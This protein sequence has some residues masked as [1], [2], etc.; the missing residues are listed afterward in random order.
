M[1]SI[2]VYLIES[3]RKG[4]GNGVATEDTK[5][6]SFKLF[7][8]WLSYNIELNN[9]SIWW[10]LN[11]NAY[12]FLHELGHCLSLWHVPNPDCGFDD[13]CDDTPT[14]ICAGVWNCVE[15]TSNCSNNIM[16]YNNGNALSPCQLG[17]IHWTLENEIPQ[18]KLCRFQ[19]TSLNVTD[20]AMPQI[21]YQARQIS[22]NAILQNNEWATLVGET[23]VNL[24]S[25]FEV[26]LGATF[27][28]KT[29]PSCQ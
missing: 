1:T 9:P 12:T 10:N 17:R 15:T 20:F 19:N 25:G 16:S 8:S 18:N 26:Q 6:K 22:S 4:V 27:E 29:T 3:G 28:A 7:G 2:N 23:E 5:V 14:N 24:N 11:V 21:L 13:F